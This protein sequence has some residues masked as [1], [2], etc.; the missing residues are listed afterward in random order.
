MS[1]EK[2][3]R[4]VHLG[5]EER[6]KIVGENQRKNAREVSFSEDEKGL[7]SL[8]KPSRKILTKKPSWK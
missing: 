3:T 8:R 7:K 6:K 2:K 5:K 4:D 1:R